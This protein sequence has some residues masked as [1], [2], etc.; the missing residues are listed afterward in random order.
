MPLL[1]TS[2]LAAGFTTTRSPTGRIFF[3]TTN[4]PFQ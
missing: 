1:V 4:S 3:S 2:S